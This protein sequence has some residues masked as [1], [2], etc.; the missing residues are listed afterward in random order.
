M[1][2]EPD[3][4]LFK[5]RSSEAFEKMQGYKY[6]GIIVFIAT[7][8]SASSV[9]SESPVAA[10]GIFGIGLAGAAF[11]GEKMLAQGKNFV[12]DNQTAI[13]LETAEEVTRL[14]ELQRASKPS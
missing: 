8:L 11:A 7:C 12:R 14:L 10:L 3:F 5:N 1:R 2:D 4:W 6:A 13:A 9:A